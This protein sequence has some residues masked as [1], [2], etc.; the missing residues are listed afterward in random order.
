MNLSITHF[1]IWSFNIGRYKCL[2]R[3][4]GV[5]S[6]LFGNLG[7]IGILI[8]SNFVLSMVPSHLDIE[9]L[10]KFVQSAQFVFIIE[11]FL[12]FFKNSLFYGLVVEHEYIINKK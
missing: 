11:S 3:D 9:K 8:E 1:Q 4:I 2:D 5:Y 12:N 7:D 10:F 6:I